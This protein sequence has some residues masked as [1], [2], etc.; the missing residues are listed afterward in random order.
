L[1]SSLPYYTH[2]A[3]KSS[4]G[5]PICIGPLMSSIAYVNPLDASDL[6]RSLL[7]PSLG[8]TEL[9]RAWR[10]LLRKRMIAVKVEGPDSFAAR[11][12][13]M[14]VFVVFCLDLHFLVPDY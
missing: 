11:L 5:F 1:L 6:L 14:R 4:N 2:K 9:H 8:I 13:A 7:R 12:F 10:K 3:I